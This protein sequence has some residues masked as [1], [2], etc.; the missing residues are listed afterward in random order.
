MGGIA[1]KPVR[2][3]GCQGQRGQ[4][5]AAKDSDQLACG[6]KRHPLVTKAVQMRCKGQNDVDA[7]A[8]AIRGQ[9]PHLIEPYRTPRYQ[10]EVGGL[11]LLS[12]SNNV[13]T[14][15]QQLR[16][17]ELIMNVYFDDKPSETITNSQWGLLYNLSQ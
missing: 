3:G 9:I 4:A 6:G 11:D 7:A 17:L 10:Y 2:I 8:G 14:N 13:S 16:K 15:R 12:L 1:A 5:E